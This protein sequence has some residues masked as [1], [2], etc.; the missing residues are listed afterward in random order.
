M[1]EEICKNCGHKKS[2]H[3][4]GIRDLHNYCQWDECEA[5][6]KLGKA[7]YVCDC[8]KFKEEKRRG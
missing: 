3:T 8:R 5:I 6:L 7:T 4:I 2:E 1:K